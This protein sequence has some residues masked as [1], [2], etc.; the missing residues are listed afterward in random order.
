ML[1]SQSSFIWEKFD[2]HRHRVPNPAMLLLNRQIR[3]LL[4]QIHR[5]PIHVN[6]DGAQ[7]EASKH[8]RTNVARTMILTKIYLF[9][10][11]GSTVPVQCKDCGLWINRVIKEVNGNNHRGWS[12][13]IHV[14]KI[15]R[16][17]TQNM[18]HI[19]STPITMEQYLQEQIK[20]AFGWL[21]D[22]FMQTVHIECSSMPRLQQQTQRH[23]WTMR[24]QYWTE[25]E[26]ILLP[27]LKS[28]ETGGRHNVCHDQP[29]FITVD[30]APNMN[31]KSS[32][33]P[34]KGE[35]R[36]RLGW[37]SHRL[38]RLRIDMY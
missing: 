1:I 8:V 24:R 9:F 36:T 2:S 30:N 13:I 32:P 14:T 23:M 4:P 33:S 15:G 28:E 34:A 3:G 17:I 26:G 20:K 6:N 35:V 29:D 10:S 21:E 27:I 19:C 31:M 22:I 5:V 11:V 38:I 25:G 16:L 12:Y 18:R 37:I 7:Y